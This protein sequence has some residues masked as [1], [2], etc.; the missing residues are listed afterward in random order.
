MDGLSSDSSLE[1]AAREGMSRMAQRMAASLGFNV[2]FIFFSPFIY[3][4]VFRSAVVK[5]IQETS[6]I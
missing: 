1:Q 2:F 6:I 3:K 4:T 5:S